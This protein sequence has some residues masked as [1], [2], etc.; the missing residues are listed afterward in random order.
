MKYIKDIRRYTF[1]LLAA[2]LLFASKLES[3]VNFY[4]TKW[5]IS[6]REYFYRI[7]GENLRYN[8]YIRLRSERK[9]ILELSYVQ[10][11][12]I[13]LKSGGGGIFS[14]P[15]HSEHYWVHCSSQELLELLKTLDI[16]TTKNPS[17][18]TS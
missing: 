10:W 3:S 2:C 12:C 8:I 5:L 6:Q 11:I 4:Q 1:T 13:L 16:T 18:R 15:E 14:L 7:R 9:V 17:L